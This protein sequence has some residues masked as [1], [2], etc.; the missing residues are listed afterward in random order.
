MFV[1]VGAE[2]EGGMSLFVG[3]EVGEVGRVRIALEEV[4]EEGW[5]TVVEAVG[6]GMCRIVLEVEEAVGDLSFLIAK[7]A[8][9]VE[10]VPEVEVE[11]T[12]LD[13]ETRCS[14]LRRRLL[15]LYLLVDEEGEGVEEQVSCAL[16]ASSPSRASRR[17]SL[18]R[19]VYPSGKPSRSL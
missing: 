15:V 16:R 1:V 12:W 11:G 17:V 7:I 9:G 14:V 13:Q 8:A 4:E 18:V 10:E 6:V 19:V 2:V 3:V 5:Y